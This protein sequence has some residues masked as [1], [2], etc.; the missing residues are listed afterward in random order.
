MAESDLTGASRQFMLLPEFV[1]PRTAVEQTIAEIWQRRLGLDQVGMN[2]RF[3]DLGGTSLTAAIIFAEIEKTFA[4]RIPMATLIDAP[5]VG[6]LAPK[7]QRLTQLK[8][9]SHARS[10]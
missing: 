7:V 5:T 6:L 8:E 4:I 1:A 3:D 9:S 10:D 2:D